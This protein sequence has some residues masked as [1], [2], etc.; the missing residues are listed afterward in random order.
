MI[1]LQKGYVSL[2]LT[3]WLRIFLPRRHQGTGLAAG[4]LKCRISTD[5]ILAVPCVPRVFA[6]KG[7]CK[8]HLP[9]RRKE[10]KVAQG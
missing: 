8:I 7:Y 6:V 9:R 2:L 5:F 3:Y 1:V 10:R 4:I